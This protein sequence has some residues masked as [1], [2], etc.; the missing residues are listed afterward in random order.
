MKK[1]LLS[2]F[3]ILSALFVMSFPLAAE[4]NLLSPAE[5]V[6][7]NKQMLVIDNSGDGDFFLFC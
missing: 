7:S 6:W 4:I 1:K 3:I 2:L 5:G